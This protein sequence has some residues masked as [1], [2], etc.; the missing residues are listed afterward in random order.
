MNNLE[1]VLEYALSRP[2]SSAGL[3]LRSE[4]DLAALLETDHFKVRK[5]LSELVRRG[6]L[7]RRHGSGTYVRKV[8]KI[9]LSYAP[10]ELKVPSKSLF[11]EDQFEQNYV[12]PLEPM[13]HQQ[14][15]HLGL[16][17]DLEPEQIPSRE[18]L[19]S[20]IVSQTERAGHFLSIHSIYGDDSEMMSAPE[21]S[22]RLKNNPSDGYLVGSWSAGM[23]L[24]A[25][26]TDHKPVVY[27]SDSSR[28]ITHEPMVLLDSQEAV[29][30]GVRLLAEYGYKRIGMISLDI[31]DDP[32]ES[33][34][35]VLKE[36][37][38]AVSDLGLTYHAAEFGQ[39]DINESMAATRRMLDRPVPPEAILVTDDIVLNGVAEVL[40]AGGIVPGGDLAV[41]AVSNVCSKLPLGVDW[42][43]LEFD[44]EALGEIIVNTLLG[45]LQTAGMRTNSSA[46]YVKWRPGKT[47][48]SKKETSR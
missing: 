9:S 48:L 29:R 31:P 47:H 18:A 35:P 32:G 7:V 27:F 13:K 1:K 20:G 19:I 24:E 11:A 4:R 17:A 22:E 37:E 39:V 21:L 42:S 40:D 46:A 14:Q 12:S 33:I 16:W 8:P 38:R 36:Y 2:P 44:A 10:R 5:S 41:I 15:L 3:R 34:E 45:L 23:F 28:P 6:V 26:G 43:R 30:R 25:M